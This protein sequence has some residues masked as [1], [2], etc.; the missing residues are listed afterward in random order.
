MDAVRALRQ[1]RHAYGNTVVVIDHYVAGDGHLD[2]ELTPL[3][4]DQ[5]VRRDLLNAYRTDR[6]P[7]RVDLLVCTQC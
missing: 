6:L 4:T 1:V 3:P 7:Q 5:A 2:V